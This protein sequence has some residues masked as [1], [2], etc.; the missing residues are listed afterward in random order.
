MSMKFPAPAI[1]ASTMIHP[2]V[3][4][5]AGVRSYRRLCTAVVI[6][7]MSITAF[8]TDAYAQRKKPQSSTVLPMTITSVVVQDGQLVANGVVGANT[9]SSPITLTPRENPQGGTCP[10]LNL[11]LG[12]IHLDL[13]GLNVDT[14]AICLDVTAEQGGGLLGNLLCSIATLLQQPGALV[15]TVLNGLTLDERNTLN[16]GLTSLLNDAVFSRITSS[17]AVTQATCSILSLELGPLHLELLGLV[18][19]LDNCMNGPITLDITAD[20]GGGLLGDLL[21]DLADLLSS[22][23]ANQTAINGLLREIAVV[24]GRIVG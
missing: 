7:L 17:N 1:P 15:S 2:T 3:I 20:P 13:L 24:I 18:V 8:T 14:S 9:F 19:D 10:I 22:G 23:R 4:P 21:C 16:A 11:Q 5:A 12:P 6:G